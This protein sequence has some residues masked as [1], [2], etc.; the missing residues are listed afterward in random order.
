MTRHMLQPPGDSDKILPTSDAVAILGVSPRTLSRWQ[1]AG[2]I[3]MVGRRRDGQRLWAAS[4]VW[5]LRAEMEAQK[6]RVTFN[7]RV[8][9]ERAG[10]RGC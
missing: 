1:A 9:P 7:P 3:R 5:R 4:E 8:N 10:A 6:P 2:R